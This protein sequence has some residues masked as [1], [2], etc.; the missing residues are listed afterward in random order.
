LVA[1]WFTASI[2]NAQTDTT[3]E[4]RAL[5]SRASA[6]FGAGQSAE[7]AELFERSLV[8][9]EQAATLYNLGLTYARLGRDDEAT[10]CFERFLELA[11]ESMARAVDDAT[12]RLHALR[13]RVVRVRLS[14][15][16]ASARVEVDGAERLLRGRWVALTPGAHVIVIRSG[17]EERRLDI[18]A[19]AGAL[20][21]RR[22]ELGATRED[23]VTGDLGALVSRGSEAEEVHETWWFWTLLVGAGVAAGVGI[24]VGVHLGT[25][26]DGGSTG[27]VLRGLQRF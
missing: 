6:A 17:A 18:E 24:G 22:I 27:V 19:R 1:V 14:G 3:A 15:V 25:Q 8:L 10:G 12:E 13:G 26:P 9:S 5:A 20:E 23:A 4:A 16:P 21:D 7:A 2:A 11:V